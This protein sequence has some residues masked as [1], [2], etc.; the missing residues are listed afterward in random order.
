MALRLR[1][2]SHKPRD[3]SVS[4]TGEALHTQDGLWSCFYNPPALPTR[5]S[6]QCLILH[7]DNVP[8][9]DTAFFTIVRHPLRCAPG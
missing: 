5:L 4:L 2:G 9:A 8:L 1:S 7:S 6:H 3:G